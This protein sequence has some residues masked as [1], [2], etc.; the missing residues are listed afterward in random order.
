MGRKKKKNRRT[1]QAQQAQAVIKANTQK[2]V[3]KSEETV[4]KK[5]VVL[6]AK[7]VQA[8]EH[9]ALVVKEAQRQAK[10]KAALVAKPVQEE[11]QP[12][13]GAVL[14]ASA[15]RKL[16]LV[17][18]KTKAKAKSKPKAKIKPQ[19]QES[20]S[21]SAEETQSPVAALALPAQ[22][23]GVDSDPV[24]DSS[25]SKGGAKENVADLESLLNSLLEKK[26]T[27]S[28]MEKEYEVY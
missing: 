10:K 24:S 8:K 16:D 9:V 21:A 2:A 19:A 4:V 27:L 15:A 25:E 6:V 22:V 3:K 14:Q 13:R 7:P 18:S 23:G 11:S 20:R 12:A 1:R 5:Q 17:F 26:K 28:G